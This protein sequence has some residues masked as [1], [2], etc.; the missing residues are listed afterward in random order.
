LGIR[1]AK[2]LAIEVKAAP[3][4]T[5]RDLSGLRTFLE[6]TPRCRLALLAHTGTS[7]VSLGERLWAI[8][9]SELLS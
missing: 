7:T 4:W 1:P 6:R 2:S 5:D 3:R 8:P 9:I